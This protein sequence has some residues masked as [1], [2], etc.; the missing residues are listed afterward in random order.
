MLGVQRPAGLGAA[1][2]RG[3]RLEVSTEA[4]Q[5]ALFWD[6]G[7]FLQKIKNNVTQRICSPRSRVGT[8][9]RMKICLKGQSMRIKFL[10]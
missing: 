4:R 8:L 10:C 2:W 7:L 5:V 1:L 6:S 9:S 3:W